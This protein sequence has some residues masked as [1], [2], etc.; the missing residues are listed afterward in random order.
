MRSSGLPFSLY[1][2]NQIYSGQLA[3]GSPKGQPGVLIN[4]SIMPE[5]QWKLNTLMSLCAK[6]TFLLLFIDDG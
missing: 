5:Q 4:K 2:V 1:R 6:M 3:G